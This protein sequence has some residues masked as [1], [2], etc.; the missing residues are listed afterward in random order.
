MQIYLF[1]I[2]IDR[3]ES[4]WITIKTPNTKKENKTANE[5]GETNW[6][7]E[8]NGEVNENV[9]LSFSLWQGD[10]YLF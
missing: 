4:K 7:T 10:N 9:T 5:K 1:F 3:T 2:L 8:L 6:Q